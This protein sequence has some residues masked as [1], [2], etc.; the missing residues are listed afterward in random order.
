MG[1]DCLEPAAAPRGPKDSAQLLVPDTP[2]AHEAQSAA[3]ALRITLYVRTSI[4]TLPSI[5]TPGQCFTV[6]VSGWELWGFFLWHR[7]VHGTS[8]ISVALARTAPAPPP[9]H[10][11]SQRQRCFYLRSSTRVRWAGVCDRCWLLRGW[12]R[13]LSPSWNGWRRR[14]VEGMKW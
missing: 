4:F 10:C 14:C 11:L 3:G 9:A 12:R 5:D 1:V 13:A 8:V 2:S 6:T 7:V